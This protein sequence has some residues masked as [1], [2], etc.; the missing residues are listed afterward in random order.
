ML[1]LVLTRHGL[2]E[3]SVPEQ[4]LGQR[5]DAPLSA[6][7]RAQ[8]E[9]L[10]ARLAGLPFDRIVASPLVRARQTAEIVAAGRPVD[11]DPRLAEMDYGAWEGY[12]YEEIAKRDGVFRRRWEADPETLACPGGESG[13]DVA[14]RALAFLADE[15]AA[16][17]QRERTILAV[18][19]SSLNRILLCVA[20]GVPVRAFRHRFVQS[21]ANLTALRFDREAGPRDATLLLLNDVAH[22]AGPGAPPWQ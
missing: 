11:A 7:G 18:A 2:T 22:L 15:L 20:L 5:I 13:A 21:P 19:H 1:V 14:A 4:H 9:H 10:A 16:S 8:A 17:Q 6:A 3:R 12:T